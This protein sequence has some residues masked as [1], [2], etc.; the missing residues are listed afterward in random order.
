MKVSAYYV[1][2]FQRQS[3]LREMFFSFFWGICSWPRLVL[4]VF[5]RRDMGE[6]YFS[7]SSAFCIFGVLCSWGI[8]QQGYDFWGTYALWYFFAL[9]FLGM[10]FYRQ[11]ELRRPAHL[12]DF[13]RFSLSAG[14][15]WEQ[16]RQVTVQGQVI[17]FS[18]KQITTLVEPSLAVVPGALLW[19]GLDQ[20]MG[21]LLVGCGLIYSLSYVASYRQGSDFLLDQIDQTICQQDLGE[22]LAQGLAPD[23]SRGATF[24]GNLP[25]NPTQRQQV[26]SAFLDDDTAY[27]V[28]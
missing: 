26:A 5:L 8:H 25:T 21:L 18:P 9:A 11:R 10:S 14:K 19:W 22:T 1:T 13:S 4:E 23:F 6:R 2:F 20:H 24:S 7:L 12:F 15:T 17:V 27:P 16:L 3:V 28:S